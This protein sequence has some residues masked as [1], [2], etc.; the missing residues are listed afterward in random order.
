M[1]SKIDGALKSWCDTHSLFLY[2]K[3]RDD[4]VR[5]MDVIDAAG[6]AH[7]IWVKNVTDDTV[8]IGAWNFRDLFA[9]FSVPIER[10]ED[11]LDAALATVRCWQQSAAKAARVGAEDDQGRQRG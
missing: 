5:G 10:L 9:E 11:G 8:V 6:R 2:T 1:Y 3:V 7:Q 4:P